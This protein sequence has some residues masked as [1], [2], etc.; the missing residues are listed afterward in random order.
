[1]AREAGG[2][3]EAAAGGVRGGVGWTRGHGPMDGGVRL[4]R[5]CARRKPVVVTGS[6]GGWLPLV[7]SVAYGSTQEALDLRGG[8]LSLGV[9]GMA[10]WSGDGR[11]AGWLCG[12]LMGNHWRKPYQAMGRHDDGDAIW[13]RSPPWRCRPG[14]DP[15]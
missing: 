2:Q 8:R 1:M 15:S 10:W 4:W 9:K 11:C 12:V 13:R 3:G 7:T 14:V 6:S 5:C